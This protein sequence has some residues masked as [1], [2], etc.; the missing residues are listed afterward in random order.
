MAEDPP[1]TDESK[2]SESTIVR[3]QVATE[4]PTIK[5]ELPQ[6]GTTPNVKTESSKTPP[7]AKEDAA[8]AAA[9]KSKFEDFLRFLKRRHFP[10]EYITK[11]VAEHVE[12]RLKTNNDDLW[13]QVNERFQRDPTRRK[14][15]IRGI[16]FTAKDD[17]MEM[18]FSQFGTV[19]RLNLMRQADN[20][21]KGFGFIMYKTDYGARAAVAQKTVTYKN[22]E[23]QISAAIPEH[24]KAN[25]IGRGGG[26]LARGRGHYGRGFPVGYG[27]GFGGYGRGLGA[28]GGFY[29][30]AFPYLGRGRCAPFWGTQWPP[31]N[32]FNTP[33][34]NFAPPALKAAVLASSNTLQQAQQLTIPAGVASYTPYSSIT[35]PNYT[36]RYTSLGSTLS[37]LVGSNSNASEQ[38]AQL[39]N[40]TVTYGSAA[41]YYAQAATTHTNTTQT[42][43]SVT[44]QLSQVAQPVFQ[45]NVATATPYQM[46]T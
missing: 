19:E 37:P 4:D 36:K 30:G 32:P 21:S 27:R 35:D 13:K 28:F 25:R 39:H 18:V 10:N 24:L 40:A 23:M 15:F 33:I 46:Y 17:E 26:P 12:K 42:L 43:G 1:N 6:G 5:T 9:R 22:R 14:I 3:A 11:T 29:G 8:L 7:K 41:A 34:Q 38:A 16:D 20:R 31:I 44:R 45:P 2:R